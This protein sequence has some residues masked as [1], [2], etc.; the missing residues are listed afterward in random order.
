MKNLIIVITVLFIS[1]KS[2][3]DNKETI[4]LE[5]LKASIDSLFNSEIKKDE[6]GAALLVS[7]KDKMLIGK[8]YGLQNLETKKP[9][10]RE[11]NMRMAS[12]SK[13]FTALAILS[14]IDQ[15]KLSLNDTV[16][17]IFPYES[18]KNV[19]IQHLINHTSGIADAESTLFKEWKSSDIAKNKDILEWYAKENR[20]ITEPG[21][22]Y[23]YNN[24]AY[25]ILPLIVEKISGQ[26]FSKYTKENIFEKA[27][28]TTTNFFNPISPVEIK[29]M[30]DCH[31]RDSLGKWNKVKPHFLNGVLGAGGVYTNIDDYF[32]YDLALR[33]KTIFSNSSIHDLIFKPSVKIPN[34]AEEL[35]Y[36][37]GWFISDKSAN[38]TGGWFGVNTC[39]IRD[40]KNKLTIAIFMNRN[41]LFKS[42]LIQKTKTL[43]YKELKLQH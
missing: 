13:Q 1:C 25:E 38:H 3:T 33:N 37:M 10:T 5:G 12:V 20:Q 32:Q 39:V 6:P 43:V 22:K 2:T 36:A 8:G 31:Q 21:E 27:G 24:G 29:E 14:L 41:T 28:M 40:I 7:Y 42:G 23:Q 17:A 34:E 18:F 15:D 26:E 35:H 9:I 4:E 30:A 11:T 19:T 16:Y